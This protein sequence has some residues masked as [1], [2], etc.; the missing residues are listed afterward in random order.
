MKD[1]PP[2]SSQECLR[3]YDLNLAEN[4]LIC[5]TQILWAALSDVL[6]SLHPLDRVGAMSGA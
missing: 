4:H 5:W 2:L 1:P 3:F 6:D